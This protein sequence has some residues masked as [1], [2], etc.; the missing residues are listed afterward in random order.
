MRPSLG[1]TKSKRFFDF[2]HR[3]SKLP[4][5]VGNYI[6]ICT[7][8]CTTRLDSSWLI[9]VVFVSPSRPLIRV[10]SDRSSHIIIRLRLSVESYVGCSKGLETRKLD[11]LEKFTSHK[12]KSNS[13][14]GA[15]L[16]MCPTIWRLLRAK[17]WYSAGGSFEQVY[18]NW[19]HA[20]ES[21]LRS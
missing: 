11:F 1:L 17:F 15:L 6:K 7:A 19:F 12:N 18:I 21:F 5:N 16:L 9:F 8:S 10:P 2:E 20:K 13:S 14:W 4:R 3:R